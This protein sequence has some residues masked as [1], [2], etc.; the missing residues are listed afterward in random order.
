MYISMDGTSLSFE[1]YKRNDRPDLLLPNMFEVIFGTQKSMGFS[2]YM[3]FDLN[4]QDQGKD[5]PRIP[6]FTCC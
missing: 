4:F 2:A 1:Y 6:I 5:V 3:Y